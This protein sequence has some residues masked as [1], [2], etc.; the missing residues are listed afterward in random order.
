M[1]QY[2][3]NKNKVHFNHHPNIPESFRM[4]IVGP[5]G[6]GKTN[7]L[8]NM[9]LTPNY[10]DY[11]NLIIFSKTINQPE[12]QVLYHGFKNGLSKESINFLFENQDKLKGISIEDTCVEYALI[13][14]ERSG[15]TIVFSDKF[16]EIPPPQKLDPKK[17]NLIIFDDC[18]NMKNQEVMESYFTRGRHQN[19]NSI[20]LSQSWFDLPGRAIRNNANEMIFFKLNKRNVDQIYTE[21]FSTVIEKHELD[22]AWANRY[23]Y[24]ALNRDTSSITTDLFTTHGGS[25]N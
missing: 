1:K 11:N 24:I 14:P 25:I 20:Y 7:L 6:C 4:L 15:I 9:L 2:T 18:V 17:K 12:Y 3:W 8:F 5:S 22:A 16:E 21:L 23:G 19:C 13:K 10:L